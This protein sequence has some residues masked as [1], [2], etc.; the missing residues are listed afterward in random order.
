MGMFGGLPRSAISMF[1][2]WEAGGKTTIR[3]ARLARRNDVPRSARGLIDAEGTYDPIWGATHGIDNED[4]LLVQP[5]T[6][7]QAL[8]IANGLLRSADISMVMVDSLAGAWSRPRNK[9]RALKTIS[10]RCRRG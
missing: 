10:W 2:G 4:M 8:D 9:K 7:E 6:G 3:G 5:E 1:Y